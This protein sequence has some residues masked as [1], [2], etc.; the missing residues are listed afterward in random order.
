MNKRN[1]NEE[2]E[3]DLLELLMELLLHWKLLLTS[4]I[5][6][7]AIAFVYTEFMI[8]PMYS[9][10]AELYVL[11]KST[12]ITSL[13]DLQLG[14]NLTNDYIVVVEG[15]PVLEQVIADLGLDMT[16][17]QLQSNV[18]ISNPDNSRILEITVTNESATLAK[19]IADEI[20]VV[21]AEFI[22]EKMDQDPP[23]V[24]QYGYTDG[25]PVNISLAK[26]TVLGGMIGLVLAAGVVVLLFLLNDTIMTTD[27]IN[28]KL[29]LNSL[30]ALPY[31]T[32]FDDEKTGDK[33]KKK[34][35]RKSA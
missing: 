10:T 17:D 34:K 24:I 20:A 29:G 13:S 7:A 15:R 35:K 6:V 23:S 12:S 32:A 21:S 19:Q 5:L 22:A 33:K 31:D 26:N 28:D 16:Y 2:M 3:I 11:S 30:G 1:Q 27:D 9:S 25:K 18:D 4:A 8:T 14:T